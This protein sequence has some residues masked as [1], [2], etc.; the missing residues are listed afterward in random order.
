MLPPEITDRKK[1][2]FNMPVAK[3]LAGP[4]RDLVEEMLSERRLREDGFFEPAVVR[5][6]L[7]EHYRAP[8]R[9]PQADL[10]AAGLPALARAAT[11]DQD[12]RPSGPHADRAPRRLLADLRPKTCPRATR[13]L[14]GGRPGHA[15]TVPDADV[16]QA[17][18]AKPRFQLR[19]LT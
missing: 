8:R 18:R 4:L 6:L 15:A 3:W 16:R 12:S 14:A 5:R 19:R 9:P 11:D 2:G 17:G 10:D 13:A 1:K 7:D